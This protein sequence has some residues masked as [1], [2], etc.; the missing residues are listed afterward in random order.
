M[1]TKMK[2][3]IMKPLRFISQIFDGKEHELEIGFPTDVKHVAHIGWDGPNVNGPSWMKE[4]HSAPLSSASYAAEGRESPPRN[5][6]ASQEINFHGGLEESPQQESV[7]PA[8]RGG[9]SSSDDPTADS[10]SNSPKSTKPRHTRRHQSDGTVAVDPPNRDPSDPSK[11]GR[12]HRRKEGG[13]NGPPT[14]AAP[15]AQELPAIPKQS[16]RR[17]IKGSG[18]SGGSTRPSRLKDTTSALSSSSSPSSSLPSVPSD[19]LPEAT[20]NGPVPVLKPMNEEE[21]GL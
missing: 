16:H 2:K 7:R 4:F 19:A 14:D 8:R 3:G 12:R 6:W 13:P 15:G 18:E 1:S 9:V 5:L 11:K 10:P 17:R 21:E 20:P